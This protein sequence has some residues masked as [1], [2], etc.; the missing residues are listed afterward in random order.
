[1]KTYIHIGYPKTASTTLQKD[2]FPAIKN[3]KY[4]GKY[5][6]PLKKFL[7]DDI[8]ESLKAIVSQDSISFNQKCV[9]RKLKNGIEEVRGNNEKVILSFEDFAQNVVDRG[10]VAE[11]L[12]GIFPDAK[13]LIII[14]NQ[15]D[16]LQSMYTFMLMHLGKNIN[17]SYGGPSVQT[18]ERWITEQ[19]SFMSRSF[20]STL[21]Y[22]E[23]ITKYWQLFGREKVTVL[24]FE[25]LVSSPDLFFDKMADYFDV[26]EIDMN[27]NKSVPKRNKGASS[28]ELFSYRIR[29][30]LFP[31]Q[32]FSKYLSLF[33]TKVWRRYL[34]KDVGSVRHE[35]SQDTQARLQD[36][37]REGNRRLQEE[38]N[39][40]LA[41]YKFIL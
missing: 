18:F 20:I 40:D 25:D 34:E 38:L 23:F 39:V 3:T 5:Y 37:F 21:N 2:I 36:Y 28:K 16:T 33:M 8:T 22:Y 1:M 24:F 31:H 4:L 29:K 32:S 6:K 17:L 30:G 7:S 13:I 35:L 11:R 41:E 19:E 14:R 10:V 9:E 12:F 26:D 27:S 15:I